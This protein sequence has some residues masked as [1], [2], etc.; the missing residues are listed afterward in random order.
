MIPQKYQQDMILDQK[1]GKDEVFV[2]V[3]LPENL[4]KNKKTSIVVK[5]ITTLL[6]S[7]SKQ[8]WFT[9]STGTWNFPFKHVNVLIP[10]G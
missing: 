8:K 3:A 1:M 6:H 10:K 5:W 2:P 7:E 4:Y 9:K